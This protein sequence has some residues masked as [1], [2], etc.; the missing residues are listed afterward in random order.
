LTAAIAVPMPKTI[1]ANMRLFPLP[2]GKH[3]TTNDDGDKA[4]ALGNRAREGVLWLLNCI[5]P[6]AAEAQ[7]R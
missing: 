3:Q 7:P 1:P 2:E 6:G 5:F 4:E